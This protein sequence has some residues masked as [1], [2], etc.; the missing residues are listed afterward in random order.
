MSADYATVPGVNWSTL[1][2]MAKS[3]LHYK[4]ACENTRD[5]T[6]AFA[7]G[8][9][10]HALVFEP[11]RVAERYAVLDGSFKL[12]YIVY[13]GGDR[14]GKVWEAF[15]AEH[16]GRLIL[17]PA[18]AD[19]I[20][21]G[22]ARCE[23]KGEVW[24]AFKAANEGKT[25]LT[26]SEAK[27]AR[28]A[29]DAVRRHRLVQRYLNAADAVFEDVLTWVDPTTD[30][31]CK[32]RLDWH[33]RSLNVLVDLKTCGNTDNAIFGR[34]IAKYDYH[35]QL[36]H[37]A[38]GLRVARG[39][40]P[41]RHVLIAVEKTAPHD[42]LVTELFDDAKTVARDNVKDLLERV[43]KCRRTNEYPGRYTEE[44]MAQLPEWAFP[45]DDSEEEAE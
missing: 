43:A 15:K 34:E 36:N 31:L 32:A 26:I 38:N 7:F 35:G 37:Y 4:H 19:A 33:A 24:E 21:E 16:S 12:D 28:D 14:R 30:L 23:R 20:E 5:D 2:H 10:V 11:H 41:H 6:P 18:E 3:P 1:K 13:E 44:Q 39:W 27:P 9:Y 45:D 22:R 25:L 42:V 40:F 8:R 17:K 29:A